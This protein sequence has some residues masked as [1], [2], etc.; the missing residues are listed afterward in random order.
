M[1][2]SS[3]AIHIGLGHLPRLG[4]GQI[5]ITNT[6][7]IHGLLLCIAEAEIV[8]EFLYFSL[9]ILKLGD[10]SLIVL[11]E[12]TRSWNLA[13]EILLGQHQRTVD[14]VAVDSH[15]LIVIARL[16]IGPSKVI[17]LGLR[18]IRGQ[19]I[20]Q[21]I[22]FAREIHKVLVEPYSPVARGRDLVALEVEELVRRYI[23]WNNIATLSL[24]HCREDNAVEDDIVFT[25]KV[26]ES[27]R[28]IFPPSLPSAKLLGLGIAE[29][30]SV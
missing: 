11:V 24:E 15:K 8:E 21:D 4:V 22:L 29:L 30:F 7:E 13:I 9:D 25:N 18:R 14:K 20:A 27:C 6:C 23:I 3:G 12:G 28:R 1:E 19:H 2:N 5:L 26:D 17:I 10:G 16:K